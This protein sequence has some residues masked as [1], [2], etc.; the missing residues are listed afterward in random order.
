MLREAVL[1]EQLVGGVLELGEGLGGAAEVPQGG[2]ALGGA[3]VGAARG[4]RTEA[5]HQHTSNT[6]FP[7]VP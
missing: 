1:L 3:G 2:G 4:G 5:Q 7:R 6:F